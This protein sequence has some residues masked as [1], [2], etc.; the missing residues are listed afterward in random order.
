MYSVLL[1]EDDFAIRDLVSYHLSRAGFRVAAAATGELALTLAQMQSF[2]A[3][4][5]DRLLPGVDG[6]RVCQELKK[7]PRTKDIPI[8]MLTALGA[9]TDVIC[10][11]KE[12]ADDYVSKP[13]SPKVLMARLEAVLRRAGAQRQ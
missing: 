3:V 7:N 2:D 11:L 1:V 9:E 13:F 5:L 8:I 10:G 12:G 4:L 6:L